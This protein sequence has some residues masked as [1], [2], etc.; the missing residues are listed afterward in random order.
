MSGKTD[1][2]REE[3]AY[4]EAGHAVVA[5]AL[6]LGVK[7]LTIDP[8]GGAAGSVEHLR[9]SFSNDQMNEY[10]EKYGKARLRIRV[11][12]DLVV[13]L[14]GEIAQSM[15]GPSYDGSWEDRGDAINRA[16]RFCDSIEETEAYVSWLH[17]RASDLLRRHWLAV[18]AV[19]RALLERKTLIGAVARR[20][21]LEA[22]LDL[23][24]RRAGQVPGRIGHIDKQAYMDFQQRRKA[25]LEE[26]D[27][28]MRR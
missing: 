5:F 24:G 21:A 10:E 18:E 16:E 6:K 17:V 13:F 3:V 4:H 2:P 22:D 9:A 15:A 26:I 25:A 20:I 19:A 1:S 14:A 27:R 12:P 8:E 7:R 28:K 11:E 23:P